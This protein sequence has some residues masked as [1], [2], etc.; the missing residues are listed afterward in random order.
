MSSKS[1]NQHEE[2]F[3]KDFSHV[4]TYDDYRAEFNR[5]KEKFGWD[6]EY[7]RFQLD[8]LHDYCSQNV[9]G[10]IPDSNV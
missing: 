8:L 10:M 3:D 7:M 1:E 4:E 6:G 5:I 2:W 9:K